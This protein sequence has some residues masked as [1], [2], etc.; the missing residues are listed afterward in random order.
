[1]RE[2]IKSVKATPIETEVGSIYPS[3]SGDKL[4]D[5][6]AITSGSLFMQMAGGTATLEHD[7]KEEHIHVNEDGTAYYVNADGSTDYR[8]APSYHALKREVNKL[9]NTL[10]NV[11]KQI[12]GNASGFRTRIIDE[13]DKVMPY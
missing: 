7:R 1:M 11:R 8:K 3:I 5:G 12:N 4:T 10:N 2:K 13:I 9:R 6:R